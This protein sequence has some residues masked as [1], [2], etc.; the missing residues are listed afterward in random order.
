VCR[1]K[2]CQA[3][4]NTFKW[5][6]DLIKSLELTESHLQ[7]ENAR[8]REALKYGLYVMMPEIRAQKTCWPGEV[9]EF[10]DRSRRAL[11]GGGG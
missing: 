5:R 7:A 4:L 1:E 8:L 11:E 9:D 2:G 6:N 10:E 3:E